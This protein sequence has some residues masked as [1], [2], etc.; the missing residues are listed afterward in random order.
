MAVQTVLI[1]FRLGLCITDMRDRL[2]V[3]ARSHEPWAIEVS[4]IDFQA[5]N[6]A[7]RKFCGTNVSSRGNSFRTV[8]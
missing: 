3:S 8:Y 4:G 7:I 1:A 6:S 2:E 5:T